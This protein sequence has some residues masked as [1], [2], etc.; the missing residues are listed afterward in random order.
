MLAVQSLRNTLMGTI[1]TATV[2]IILNISLAALA[3][4]SYAASN[5]LNTSPLFGSQTSKL[6]ILKFG[7]TCLLLIISFLCSTLA[8][9]TL[10][11]ANILVNAIGEFASSPGYVRMIFERGFALSVVGN[12]VLCM[13][14]PVLFWLFGPVS[15]VVSS[16]V[17]VWGLYQLDFCKPVGKFK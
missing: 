17:L 14:F 11:D 7:S 5:I 6:L 9:C 13:A 1:L 3:N 4:N 16:V 2:T 15:V 12:R 10:I 8:M